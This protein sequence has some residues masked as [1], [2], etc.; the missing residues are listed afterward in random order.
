MSF[1]PISIENINENFIKNIGTEWM[2]IS[3]GDK[4]GYNMMTAS[5]GFM[6]VMWG[7][8]CAVVAIRP[9]RYTINFVENKDY[10]ALSFYGD[11]KSIHSVCGK[12][13]GKDV[14][15]TEKA[16]LTPIFDE[17]T[18]TPYFKEARLVLICKKVYAQPLNESL[19]LDKSIPQKI[20]PNKDYHKMFYGQIISAYI[21]E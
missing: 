18:D 9:Q 21:K 16:E 19:F 2:L 20:Y 4:S 7:V 12:L 11:D 17:T 8:P 6:G 14:N 3:A 15:K 5:W 10:Y 1:K 13:S